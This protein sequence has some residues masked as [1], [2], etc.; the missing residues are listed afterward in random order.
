MEKGQGEVSG[1]GI[2]SAMVELVCSLDWSKALW[3]SVWGVHG[4]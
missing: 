2:D 3:F 1:H 4:G